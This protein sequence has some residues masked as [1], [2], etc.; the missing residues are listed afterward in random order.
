MRHLIVCGK[1]GLG[2]EDD[3]PVGGEG[4]ERLRRL[5]LSPRSTTRPQQRLYPFNKKAPKQLLILLLFLSLWLLCDSLSGT[6]IFYY[7]TSLSEFC[8]DFL[9]FYVFLLRLHLND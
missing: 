9:R 6:T 5:S 7:F 4:D 8:R 3:A 2:V 1:S